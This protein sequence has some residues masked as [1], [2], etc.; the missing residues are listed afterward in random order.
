MKPYGVPRVPN[1]E[2]PD[3][4]DI[5]EF[6]MKSSTG[7]IR[8]KSGEFRGSQKAD[9][10]KVARRRFKKAARRQAID[11]D[12]KN[13]LEEMENEIDHLDLEAASQGDRFDDAWMI[14]DDEDEWQ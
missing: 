6:G 3:L 5:A 1:T 9:N 14:E 13:Q 8:G 11:E 4:A 2:Y 10:R 7:Q 12:I